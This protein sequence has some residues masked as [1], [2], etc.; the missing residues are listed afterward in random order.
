MKFPVVPFVP[1]AYHGELAGDVL[2][3]QSISTDFK[4]YW[5]LAYTTNNWPPWTAKH[6]PFKTA[7]RQFSDHPTIYL[8]SSYFI[9]LSVRNSVISLAIVKRNKIGGSSLIQQASLSSLHCCVPWH[10]S[11]QILEHRYQFKVCWPDIL[12][13]DPAVCFVTSSHNP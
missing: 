12:A 9:C 2:S 13:H 10:L 7:I 5:L 8:T 1:I 6:E 3:H 11:K 4:L